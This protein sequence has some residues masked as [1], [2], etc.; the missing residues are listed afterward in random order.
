MS[1]DLKAEEA[2]L[3]GA[4]ALAGHFFPR[5]IEDGRVMAAFENATYFAHRK[6]QAWDFWAKCTMQERRT[7]SRVMRL[8]PPELANV[9]KM[10]TAT[11]AFL[12]VMALDA[13]GDDD[14]SGGSF[15]LPGNDPY[16]AEGV[17]P[18]VGGDLLG[19]AARTTDRFFTF[20]KRSKAL[21]FAGPGRYRTRTAFL[22][23]EHGT[24]N[25]EIEFAATPLFTGPAGHEQLPHLT[26]RPHQDSIPIP[27]DELMEVAKLLKGRGKKFHYLY[28]VLK[29]F[30]ASLKSHDGPVIILDLASGLLQIINAPTGSGKTVLVRA[31]ASWAALHGIKVA[32]GVTDAK[33][34]LAMAWDIN[35]DLAHLHK[36]GHLAEPASCVPLM[37]PSSRHQRALDYASY[38]ASGLITS[39]GP[40]QK[41]DIGHLAY[42]CAQRPLM[43]PPNLYRPGEE[44]C[45]SLSR[46]GEDDTAYACPFIPVCGKFTPLYMA[47]DAA[48]IVTN[49]A[50]LLSGTLRIG[51]VLDGA[52]WRGKARA[53]RG[54]SVLEMVLRACDL[55]VIDEV[56]AFQKNVIGRCTSELTLASR[57]RA[58]DLRELDL[59]AKR[60]PS[61]YE[62]GLLSPVSQARLMSELLLLSLGNRLRMNPRDARANPAGGG[63]NDGWRLAR[64]RDRELLQL[65]FPDQ[66]VDAEISREQLRL[67]DEL[68]P[69]RWRDNEHRDGTAESALPE[70]ADWQAVHDA[71]HALSAPRGEDHLQLVQQELNRLLRPA[72]PDSNQRAAAVNLLVTR[73]ILK[74]ID[75]A[76]AFTRQA[77]QSLRHLDLGSVRRILDSIKDSPVVGLYPLAMLGHTINGYQ[78]RGLEKQESEAELLV[79]TVAGDPHTFT[80]QLGGL[81]ALMTAGVERP[82]L[83]LSATAYFPQAVQEHI[84]AP[85]KWWIPDT[86]P[87]SIVTEPCPVRYTD[88]DRAG[89][90]ISIGGLYAEAKPQALRTLGKNLYQQV[91]SDRL[92]LLEQTE[93]QRARCILAVN[94]YAQVSYL[95]AGLAQAEGLR[96]R[97]CAVVR[98][99]RPEDY[100]QHIPSF[101]RKMVREELETF[102]SEGEILIVPL[103]IIARGLNILVETRSAVRD[104]Y[105][106]TRPVLSIEDIEWM[107]GS[108]NAAGINA[109]PEGG[110]S[111]P[112]AALLEA[113]TVSRQQIVRILRSP[114]RFTN[115]AH[116]LQEELVAGMLIDLVQLAGRARRGDTDMNLYIVDYALHRTEFSADLASIIRRIHGNWSAEQ[117][118]FMNELYGEALS[119][120]LSYAGINP[121]RP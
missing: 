85:V 42:S 22:G 3:L 72:I 5:V 35:G 43:D 109:L 74:E 25:R 38:V 111:D 56:D 100:E 16:R 6:P 108:I 36:Q 66:G 84:H 34:T 14:R 65:L 77:A 49:H 58:S 89:D 114:S 101:V 92:A 32:M 57:K 70:G 119:S 51:A 76:L 33:A 67:L 83:G 30:L 60:L 37:S 90:P 24:T 64:S 113:E 7:V 45:L 106:C 8:L 69:V 31:I 9:R 18:R 112:V 63:G 81:T 2:G 118:A 62:Q 15:L 99:R 104:I 1:S 97:I 46:P 20:G 39:W 102:A 75:E 52:E 80:S 94:S 96:H 4:L 19:F 23:K 40:K 73:A 82:V 55:V 26:T 11:L 12:G 120:F 59:D 105:L 28:T 29:K 41:A 117:L 68:M 79:R 98:G 13:D 10:K 17:I 110:S 121:D 86:R 116:E 44:N 21:P 88:G 48:V 103:A 50:N 93:P 61:N 53:T 115:M 54:L 71:L 27:V 87:K 47:A 78:A 95:A 91:L 107:H